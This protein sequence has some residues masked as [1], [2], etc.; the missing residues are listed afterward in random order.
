MNNLN[1]SLKSFGL[2]PVDWNIRRIQGNRYLVCHKY[3]VGFEFQGQVEYRN[4]K[5]CWKFLRLSSI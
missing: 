3:D 1:L 4:F 2:N 5:P